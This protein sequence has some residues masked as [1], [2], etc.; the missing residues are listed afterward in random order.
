M[1]CA[2]IFDEARIRLRKEVNARTSAVIPFLFQLADSNKGK[3]LLKQQH[4]EELNVKEKKILLT[5]II[6][7][8]VFLFSSMAMAEYAPGASLLYYETD[9]G[10]GLWQYDYTVYNTSTA[11]H[12]LLSIVLWFPQEATITGAPLPTGWESGN[13]YYWEGTNYTDQL[14]ATSFEPV[15]DITPGNSLNG[16]SFTVDYRAG[17]IAYDTYLTGS[18]VASGMTAVA[19]EP[20]SSILFLTGGAAL[21]GRNYLRRWRTA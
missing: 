12:N 8:A 11:D 9:L 19:P 10:G 1:D 13:G 4:K 7:A 17:D 2:A 5:T 14:S 15:Y 3:G 20:I 16:F 21:A 18:G 6:A